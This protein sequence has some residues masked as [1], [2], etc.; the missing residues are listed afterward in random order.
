MSSNTAPPTRAP[1]CDSMS[2]SQIGST[3]SVSRRTIMYSSSTPSA[4]N[5]RRGAVDACPPPA[6][7]RA[8]ADPLDAMDN[9]SNDALIEP[10]LQHRVLHARV[11]AGV[12]VDLDDVR[13][14]VDLLD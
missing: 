1:V 7:S 4:S 5:M 6:T 10:V 11:D 3:S 12:V 14:A 2:L 9:G 13:P 8:F